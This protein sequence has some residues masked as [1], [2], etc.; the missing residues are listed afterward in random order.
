MKTLRYLLVLLALT[1]GVG[2]SASAQFGQIF[3]RAPTPSDFC[4]S[5]TFAYD[6]LNSQAYSC[7]TTTHVW[8]QLGIGL[9]NAIQIQLNPFGVGLASIPGHNYVW[10]TTSNNFVLQ[11]KAVKD[12]RDYGADVT[13]ATDTLAAWNNMLISVPVGT[14][15]S[16]AV[17]AGTF[18]IAGGQQLHITRNV[19]I[20]GAGAAQQGP[21]TIIKLGPGSNIVFEKSTVSSDGGSSDFSVVNDVQVVGTTMSCTASNASSTLACNQNPNTFLNLSTGDY[22]MVTGVNGALWKRF[23]SPDQAIVGSVTANSITLA[24]GVLPS[25]SGAV[26]VMKAGFIA[27]TGTTTN[28]SKTISALGA[29]TVFEPGDPIEGCGITYPNFVVARNTVAHTLT[30]NVAATASACTGNLTKGPLPNI[31]VH[32]GSIHI[33]DSAGIDCASFCYDNNGSAQYTPATVADGNYLTYFRALRSGDTQVHFQGA[34]ANT[35][36]TV[37]VQGTNSANGCISDQSFLGNTHIAPECAAS[38]GYPYFTDNANATTIFINAYIE[39]GQKA[40]QYGPQTIVFGGQGQSK[41]A[42]GGN[43]GAFLGT[44]GRM[45]PSFYV[46]NLQGAAS[47]ATCTNG[48]NTLTNVTAIA[49]W[50]IGDAINSDCLP[51]STTVTNTDSVSVLTTSN[52]ANSP[53]DSIPITQTVTKFFLGTNG[54]NA[55]CG[56]GYSTDNAADFSYLCEFDDPAY[57]VAG[58]YEPGFW[59]YRYRNTGKALA[60]PTDQA[61]NSDDQVTNPGTTAPVKFPNGIRVGSTT[62]APAIKVNA[63]VSAPTSGEWQNGS[64]A[65]SSSNGLWQERGAGKSTTGLAD[66][67]VGL[68][69]LANQDA[70]FLG[71]CAPNDRVSGTGIQTGTILT[72]QN[73][74]SKAA[75]ATNAGVT[76]TCKRIAKGHLATTCDTVSGTN[77]CLNASTISG[78][79]INDS[80][81]G[82]GIP[83]GTFV[84]VAPSGNTITLSQNATAS[85]SGVSVAAENTA[86]TKYVGTVSSGT[87]VLGTSAI[88]ANTCATV[89]T[90]SATGV[91][92]TDTIIWSFSATPGT[93]YTSGLYILS[94]TTA[95]NVNFLVC[96]PTAG[97]LTPA[98]AT[99]NWRVGQ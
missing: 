72:D 88:S 53:G 98:A 66:L 84:L 85:N 81:S 27:T 76:V 92:T 58:T 39:G 23:I 10:N 19:R 24:S 75:T 87:A 34:D 30:L 64:L 52:N 26:T 28:A 31:Q 94:Y 82:T 74:L 54:L 96:N 50:H 69:A 20:Q 62:A 77:T 78:W 36:V 4:Y 68:K 6:T 91:A 83:A 29:D 47:T 9:T 42:G 80:I 21:A 14:G 40:P 44:D 3:Y 49:Q 15:L 93:G 71:R 17:P 37:G 73:T 97:S 57:R 45:S 5:P 38:D 48:L 7:N 11:T 16:T 89:V 86:F 55:I 90:T 79:L 18:L 1:V 43:N 51:G 12:I 56:F 70:N 32:A 60:F 95:N 35:A 2:S 13:G 33:N 25:F 22:I 46:K 59:V 8:Q 65:V 99:L 41:G 67:T 63:S 61:T